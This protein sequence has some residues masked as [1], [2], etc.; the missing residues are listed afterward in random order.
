MIRTLQ[1]LVFLAGLAVVCWVGY[2]YA[3]TNPLA[4]AV[5]LLVGAFYLTGALELRRYQQATDSLARATSDLETAP[6]SLNGWLERLHPSLR[7]AARL[8]VE[9]E[10]AALPGPA[11]TPYLVGLLVL[12]GMLGTFLGMVATL[13]GTG[14]ALEGATDLHAIR[15]SLAAPVKGLGFAFG[16]SVA[17]VAA[18]AMLGLLA[19]LCRR[20][21]L[22]ASQQLDARIAG[23][24]RAYSLSHQREEVYRLL[25]RQS[26]ALPALADRLGALAEQMERQS[27]SLNE[28]LLASQEA[29]HGKTEAAYA[30][31]SG[32]LETALKHSVAE[33]A[34]AAGA[35]IQPAAEA[36][37]ASLAR[38]A[39]SWQQGVAAA[40][41]QQLDGVSAR[42]ENATERV[43]GLWSQ[44][45]AG[46]Q[47]ANAAL[48]QS[49]EQ[50]FARYAQTFEERSASLV[51]TVSARM[52]AAAGGVSQAWTDALTR[53]E[54]AGRRLT[55]QQRQ[56]LDDATAAFRGHAEA[57]LASLQSS[58]ASLQAQLAERDDAR[59]ESWARSLAEVSAALRAQWEQ[60]S[61][62]AAQQQQ[63]ICETLAQT[64]REIAEQ[65]RAHAAGTVAEIDRLVQAAA[66]APQAAARMH[67][68]LAAR[69]AE[70]LQVWTGTLTDMASSLRE[71]WRRASEQAAQR[72]QQVCDTLAATV[73]DIS[74]QTEAHAAN[75]I[76][77]IDRLVQAAAEAP[78]AAARMHTDLAA[79]D[80]ERLQAWTGTLAD[81]AA[82]L[83][84][85]WRLASEQAAGRQQEICDAL[86]S[87]ARDIAA[88]GQAH[89][90]RTLAEIDRLVQAA[91]EAP[92]AA[93]ELAAQ[94]R[95]QVSES[96]VR[97][98]AMLEERNRLLGTLDTL[99]QAVNEATA[100]QRAAVE[101]LVRASARMLEETGARFAGRIDAETGRIADVA[102]QVSD[103]ALDVA[104]LGEAFGAAV[105]VFSE[106]SDK[107]VAHLSRVESA[108]DKSIARS[109]EQLAY[110]VAQAR[111]VIDLSM[112]SQKQIIE[113]LQQLATERAPDGAETA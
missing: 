30:R 39:A 78:Q 105:Q 14:L 81:M 68:D 29:F 50:T 40:V 55:G 69:D 110:Y 48:G 94:V 9:G 57:L 86:A 97:D 27:Q 100:E 56:A 109:D 10:R 90:A 32:T 11:L 46:Q 59:R 85:E 84:E 63:R 98:N 45:V 75:T 73:R 58:H 49:L 52:E 83:R 82:S 67:T 12:L 88:G 66:E 113:N 3:P 54:E 96:L 42:L 71:E 20:E 101:D 7:N 35:A 26:E 34:R 91:S 74:A 61:A 8:R 107:L 102:A 93:A 24:L 95:A 51:D 15:A 23:P 77:E 21:R 106:S 41:T 16:T 87:A 4:L 1:F 28:R 64:A 76:A 104:S 17:G 18:S 37:M 89:A 62:E 65:N 22:R 103:G 13:R 43:A 25:Q 5:T 44:A 72:Q 53:Q 79:R 38:E 108:L 60:A 36:T 111:E 80:A 99:A 2:S 92:R 19:S 31:L 47:Q 112:L 6:A 70:R 33:S